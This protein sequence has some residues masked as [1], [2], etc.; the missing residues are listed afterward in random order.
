MEKDG[1]NIIDQKLQQIVGFQCYTALT[2]GCH[3]WRDNRTAMREVLKTKGGMIAHTPKILV[4]RCDAGRWD[5]K[6]LVTKN[7][8]TIGVS[9]LYSAFKIVLAHRAESKSTRGA[10]RAIDEIATDNMAHYALTQNHN[11]LP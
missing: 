4:G 9:N 6:M 1:L 11:F 10:S 5:A 7:V 2:E 3:L 8:N